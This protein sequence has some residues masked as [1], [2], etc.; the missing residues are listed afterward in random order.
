MSSIQAVTDSNNDLI[1]FHRFYIFEGS[2]YT[3]TE[4]PTS[5]AASV[6]H[7]VIQ[8]SLKE[9]ASL[10]LLLHEHYLKVHN[11]MNMSSQNY[12]SVFVC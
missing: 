8:Q 5:G 3:M 7:P 12:L 9:I 2:D 4:E 10:L 6:A 11:N 1:Y